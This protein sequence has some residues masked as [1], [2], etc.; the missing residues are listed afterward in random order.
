MAIWTSGDPVSVSCRRFESITPV[1]VAV[2]SRCTSLQSVAQMPLASRTPALR[3]GEYTRRPPINNLQG[4]GQDLED[5][6]RHPGQLPVG[7]DADR[8]IALDL[9]SPRPAELDLG[10]PA[11][12][13]AIQH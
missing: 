5:G 13:A 1:L 4:A 12:R 8:L 2:A 3:S 10:Q 9:N 11:M 7:F 6:G